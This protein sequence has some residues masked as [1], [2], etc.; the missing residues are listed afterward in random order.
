MLNLYKVNSLQNWQCL[1][2]KKQLYRD[3]ET[4]KD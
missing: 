2:I 1:K 3:L 4:S